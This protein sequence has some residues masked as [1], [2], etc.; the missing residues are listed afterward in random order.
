MSRREGGVSE[1]VLWVLGAAQLVILLDTS[2][3]HVALPSIR[4][5][6]GLPAHRLQW[7][8]TA[9]ALSFGGFLLLGGRLGDLLGRR[10][11]LSAGMALFAAASA[12]G[13]FAPDGLALI[14]ARALQGLGAALA[15]P[16]VLALLA[17]HY[18]EGKARHRALGVLGTVSSLGFALGLVLGGLLTSAF[19]WR[20]VFFVNVPVGAALVVLAPRV[21]RES[22]RLR[23][24]LDVPG[25]VTATAGLALL[26]YA[27]SSAGAAAGPESALAWVALAGALVLLTAFFLVEAHRAAPLVPPALLRSRTFAGALAIGGAFGAIMG[28]AVFL[29]TLYLQEALG[30]DPLRTGF[31]FLPQECVVLLAAPLAGRAVGRFGA[32]A[33]LAAGMGFFGAGMLTLSG[34]SAAGDY[35]RTVVPGLL[36]VGLGVS[37]V[38]VA[39]AAA[40]TAAVEPQR[41]GVASGLW[42]TMPQLGTAIGVA[43]LVALARLQADGGLDPVHAAHAAAAAGGVPD[44]TAGDL[45]GGAAEAVSGGAAGNPTG[46]TAAPAPSGAVP[47]AGFRAA[48]LAAAGIAAA[49]LAVALAGMKDRAVR[50][51]RQSRGRPDEAGSGL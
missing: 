26:V 36:L 31:A 37:C 50:V 43:A 14:A 2:I 45:A 28:T 46:G 39:G 7:T 17:S 51:S 49:G 10:R 20:W 47:I 4:E 22:E 18:P 44:G 1:G 21:L 3:V 29:L 48:F 11:M 19:G 9:Y 5:E 42:N 41:H 35:W 6:F 16:A 8:V 27:C 40:V 15:A 23:Q 32:R 34:L 38:I 24:P 13:G 25:T 33:V 30:F 12:L